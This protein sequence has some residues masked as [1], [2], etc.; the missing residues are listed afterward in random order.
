MTITFARVPM[1]GRWRK[2]IQSSRTST[3]TMIS[4]VPTGMPEILAK[5]VWKTSQGSTP[6]PGASIIASLTP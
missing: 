5:P 1:P 4:T 2:G 6:T 3:P